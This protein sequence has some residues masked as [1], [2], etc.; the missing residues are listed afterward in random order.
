[1]SDPNAPKIRIGGKTYSGLDDLPP[2]TR[3]KLEQALQQMRNSGLLEDKNRDGIPDRFE[4]SLRIAGWLGKL[5]GNP[6]LKERLQQQI[7]ALGAS[8]NVTTIP[9]A[10]STPAT[11]QPSATPSASTSAPVRIRT[12]TTVSSQSTPVIQRVSPG[13]GEEST[14]REFLRKLAIV[15][16]VVIAGYLIVRL[17][18]GG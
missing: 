12:T 9:R 13:P 2:E 11:P 10:S 3:Q 17:M 8:P 16:A 1:M 4:T 5:T 7:K 14:S 15:S 18:G 6:Q